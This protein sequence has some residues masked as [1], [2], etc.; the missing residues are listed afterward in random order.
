MCKAAEKGR[1]V[2]STLAGKGCRGLSFPLAISMALILAAIAA[3]IST[4]PWGGSCECVPGSG[5]P[6]GLAAE[7]CVPAVPPGTSAFDLGR[8]HR[9]FR[10]LKQN[11]TQK[12]RLT[13]I[14]NLMHTHDSD[15]Y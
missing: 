9:L 6:G 13:A 11:Q 12:V 8:S 15:V 5:G 1:A 10:H 7:I 4:P 2:I 3:A 14:W